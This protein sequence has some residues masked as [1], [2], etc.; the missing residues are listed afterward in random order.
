MTKLRKKGTRLE[1]IIRWLK[2]GEGDEADSP[3]I[4]LDEC[5]K[6]QAPPSPFALSKAPPS[7]FALSK[8][9]A[10]PPH[11]PFALS[12]AH[13]SPLPLS[14]AK[15]LNESPPSKTALCVLAL[16]AAIPGARVL[17]CSATG[18]AE[19]KSLT[20]MVRLGSSGFDSTRELLSEVDRHGMGAM[21]VGIGCVRTPLSSNR[22]PSSAHPH[23]LIG[24]TLTHPTLTH[25]PTNQPSPTPTNISTHQLTNRHH[26]AFLT[27]TQHP[28]DLCYGAKSAGSLSQ[29]HAFIQGRGV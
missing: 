16:Q 9:K 11:P 1:Q 12:K 23:P 21:E 20:Y 17:Y 26:P 4:V 3:L 6:V 24:P 25:P 10:P 19:P 5:H 13:P 22:I 28:L 27:S 7:P 14:K 18:A 29:P 8:A 2:G 15:N